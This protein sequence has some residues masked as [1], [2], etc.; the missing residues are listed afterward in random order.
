WLKSNTVD[1]VKKI[2][3]SLAERV[4]GRLGNTS[5]S[6]FNSFVVLIKASVNKLEKA[7]E[8]ISNLEEIRKAKETPVPIISSSPKE[9]QEWLKSISD[10]VSL[11]D[12]ITTSV[13]ILD[14]G[15][16]YNNMLLS[17]VCCDDFSVSWDPDW[18]KY[19]QYQA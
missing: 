13:S 6:F 10:R 4:D 17:K 15:I 3:E 7:P 5:L 2:A 1:D 9:Q 19:D 11:S 8:L 16:N 14:T 18:P 12:N